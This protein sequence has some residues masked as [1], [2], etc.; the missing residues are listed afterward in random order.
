MPMQH[1]ANRIAREKSELLDGSQIAG[2]HSKIVQRLLENSDLQLDK[3]GQ[4][5]IRWGESVALR[6]Y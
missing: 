2:K 5:E 6:S 1:P 4:P 3:T